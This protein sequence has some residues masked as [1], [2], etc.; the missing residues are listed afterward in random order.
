MAVCLLLQMLKLLCKTA[1]GYIPYGVAR[2]LQMHF[3]H[4]LLRCN[5]KAMTIGPLLKTVDLFN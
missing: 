4:F 2:F 3:T 5:R 1:F